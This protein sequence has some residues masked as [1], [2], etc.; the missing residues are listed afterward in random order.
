MALVP[1]ERFR[2]RQCGACC[3]WPGTVTLEAGEED[4]IAGFLGMPIGDFLD[5][6]TC[7]APNRTA[8]VLIDAPGTTRC[9]FLDGANRC[10][11]H[12]VRPRQCRSY[13]FRWNEPPC[14][15]NG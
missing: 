1:P 10:A 8:L 4:A 13:P 11:I 6:Y 3:S 5:R 12:P 15:N 7:L 14:P 2:C 9:V